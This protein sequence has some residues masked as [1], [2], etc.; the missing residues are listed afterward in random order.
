M[1]RALD[2]ATQ[3]AIRDRS[4][5][6]PRNFV[7]VSA[8]SLVDGSIVLF[9]FTDY[10]EDVI[11]NVVDGETG[12]TVSRTYSGDNSPIL[13]MDPMPIKIGLEVDTT[14]VVL[15]QIHPAVQ[16]MVRGHDVRNA[17]VQIH[18]GYLDPNSML[19]VAPPRIRRLGQVNGAP[20]LTPEA[21]SEGSI[22]LKVVSNTRE[23]TRTNSALKSDETQRLRSGDRFRRYSSV[24]KW[25]YWWGEA[26]S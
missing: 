9:G 7:L 26:K 10:G 5:I 11:V 12:S 21:G 16:D 19:L 15:S 20:I 24:V 3:T 18:R 22:T 25:N 6:L 2:V 13:R 23:M 17:K 1:T 14:Q 8:K 4:R